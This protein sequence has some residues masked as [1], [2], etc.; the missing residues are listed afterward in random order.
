MLLLQYRC[1]ISAQ[2]HVAFTVPWDKR[3]SENLIGNMKD[4]T[5]HVAMLEDR[6]IL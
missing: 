5:E 4:E 1:P 2:H 6:P 3:Y